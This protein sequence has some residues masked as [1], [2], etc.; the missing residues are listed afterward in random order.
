MIQAAPP[1]VF[2]P[3]P[4]P[5]LAWLPVAM[6]SVEPEYQRTLD[7]RRSQDSVDRIAATFRWAKFGVVI[8]ASK[9]EGWVIVDGQHRVEAARRRKLGTVPCVVVP[10]TSIAERAEIFLATNEKRVRINAFTLFWARAAAGEVKAVKTVQLSEA[11]GLTIT[12]YPVQIS[13]LKPGHT[14]GAGFLERVANGPLPDLARRALSIPGSVYKSTP[15]GATTIILQGCFEAMRQKPNCGEQIER[16]LQAHKPLALAERY[17]GK[18]AD[19]LLADAILKFNPVHQNA[20]RARL[21]A[22]R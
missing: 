8:V 4:R 1:P 17:R 6:L 10:A 20:D 15:G 16:F 2:D 7:S 12:R 9:G 11:C 13:Q 19:A 18:G 3:G 22:G 5:E 14:M 21:M